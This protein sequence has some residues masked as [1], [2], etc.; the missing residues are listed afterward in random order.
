MPLR[1]EGFATPEIAR[2]WVEEIERR[3]KA[4]D[5][6]KSRSIDIDAALA[7]M[8]QALQDKRERDCS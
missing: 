4:H 8:R 6:D 2:A 7:L 3:I 5:Q 1:D